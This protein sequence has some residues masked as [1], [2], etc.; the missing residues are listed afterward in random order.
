M[1]HALIALLFAATAHSATVIEVS[2]KFADV[3]AGLEIPTSAAKLDQ[4]KGVEVLS[5]PRVTTLPGKTAMVEITQE[6]MVPGSGAVPI[7][8]TLAVTP[9]LGEKTISFTGKA[10]DRASHGKRSQGSVNTVEFATREIYFEGSTASGGTVLLHTAPV[11]T[12]TTTNNK[13]VTKQR[14]LVVYLTFTKKVIEEKK[15]VA[16]VKKTAPKATPK[17]K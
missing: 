13:T 6:V 11:T 9:T 7:G 3:P 1:K 17:K 4:L 5:A 2:A 14:E 12:K 10:M 15:P 8:L 16:P